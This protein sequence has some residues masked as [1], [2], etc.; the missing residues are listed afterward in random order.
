MKG[1]PL[2][3]IAD[4]L[5]HKSLAMTRRYAHLGP[6]RLHE[7]VF[8]ISTVGADTKTDSGAM[9]APEKVSSAQRQTYVN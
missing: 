2:E 3:D 6:S 4:L 9:T 7:L 5:G 1:V 8:F